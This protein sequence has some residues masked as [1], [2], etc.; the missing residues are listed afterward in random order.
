MLVSES[1]SVD[2]LLL[3]VKAKY[4]QRRKAMDISFRKCVRK[5]NTMAMAPARL[6]LLLLL[7]GD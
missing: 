1:L 3:F 7:R 6:L 2:N 4:D 5:Q